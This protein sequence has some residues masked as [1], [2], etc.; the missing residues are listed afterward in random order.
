MQNQDA[1]SCENQ[2]KS[3]SH[4]QQAGIY[5]TIDPEIDRV[6]RLTMEYVESSRL[7]IEKSSRSIESIIMSMKSSQSTFNTYEVNEIGSVITYSVTTAVG[8][9]EMFWL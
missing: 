6:D 7:A 2:K 1:W 4:V 5:H 8:A 3:S 9:N